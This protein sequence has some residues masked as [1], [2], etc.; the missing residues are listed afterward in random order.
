[1][2]QVCDLGSE[3]I[4]LPGGCVRL[5]ELLLECFDRRSDLFR[6]FRDLKRRHLSFEE[7]VERY[8]LFDSVLKLTY[9]REVAGWN[10]L[11][12]SNTLT[13]AAVIGEQTQGDQETV[14]QGSL[15][16]H[17][18]HEFLLARR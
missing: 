8:V 2:E 11:L 1:M 14:D 4:T 12:L 10:C 17:R 5:S 16:P 9:Q 18:F 15:K 13:R 7:P 3:N 6:I